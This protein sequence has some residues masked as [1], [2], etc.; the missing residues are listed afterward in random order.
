MTPDQIVRAI[1]ATLRGPMK[2]VHI[3][4]FGPDAYLNEDLHLDSVL[5]LN[6]LL[7]L[8]TNHGCDVPER[9]LSKD[10][11]RTVRDLAC[12][13]A[14]EETAIEPED[15]I[16]IKVHCFVSCLCAAIKARPGMDHRPFYFGVW[17]T[18]FHLDETFRL[19]Y[20]GPTIKHD[21]FRHWFRRLYGVDVIGWYN[22][23]DNK[24]ANLARFERLLDEKRET[25]HLMVM[26]DLYHL[27][28][29]ENKFNQNPFP[30]YVM[31]EKTDNPDIWFMHDPDYRWEGT[32]PRAA[33]LNAIGQPTVEGGYIFD[34]AKATDPTDVDLRNYFNAVFDDTCNPLID[35]TR[36]IVQAHVDPGT[37]L[38][39]AALDLALRELPVIAIRKYAYE[40]GFAVFW[41]ALNLPDQ[42]FEDWCDEI[43]AL[44]QGFRALQYKIIKLAASGD[45]V[46]TT[47]IFA[48]LDA[49]DR[50]EFRIK[51][52]LKAWY[53][54]WHAK[55]FASDKSFFAMTGTDR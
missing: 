5:I 54:K 7:H 52:G 43:E 12:F 33:I 29:R 51:T 6:L 47:Q 15:E 38:D 24:A 19:S 41:R 34:R 48:D 37:L 2:N 28:E 22:K 16:D 27:P 46:L 40:H 44:H 8:E 26:L 11:F 55:A 1:E 21:H 10:S 9:E 35:V 50:R 45:A 4:D 23:D 18:G 25:E 20:H 13:L 39:I 17:D 3:A 53:I 42:D 30:H 14:G 36:Q 49:L 32:L 31:I